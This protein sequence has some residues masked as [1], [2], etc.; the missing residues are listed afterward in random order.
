MTVNVA[1]IVQIIKCEERSSIRFTM[2]IVTYVI[3]E[4]T[5]MLQTGIFPFGD[6]VSLLLPLLL[7]RLPQRHL[8]LTKV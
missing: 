2:A 4:H 5:L 3:M 8:D 1:V 6:I 7:V